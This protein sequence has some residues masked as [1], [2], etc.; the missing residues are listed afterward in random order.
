MDAQ[1]KDSREQMAASR[2][3][4]EE[5]AMTRWS[6][7]KAQASPMERLATEMAADK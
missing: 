3:K 1:E 5:A 7:W 4:T 6:A 2:R